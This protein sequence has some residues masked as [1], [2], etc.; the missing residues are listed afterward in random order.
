MPRRHHTFAVDT[1]WLKTPATGVGTYIRSTIEALARLDTVNR[2]KLWGAAVSTGNP[3]F[4]YHRF[5]GRWQWWWEKWWNHFNHP[6]LDMVGPRADLWHFTNYGALPT[7]KPYVVSVCDLAWLYYPEQVLPT[8]L[9][10]LKAYVPKSL[11]RAAHV[12]TISEATKKDIVKEFG[13]P[14]SR[15]SV[16]HLAAGPQFAKPASGQ[17]V[18][19]LKQKYGIEGDYLL[20]VGTLEPRKNLR[21]LLEA[22]VTP[23]GR[24]LNLPLVVVGGQGWR[25][26]E[27]RELIAKLGL[28]NR[29]ILTGYVPDEELPALYCGA[30]LFVFPS[31][32]EG[33]GIPVVEAMTAGAAVITTK[34]SAIPEV[35]GKAARYV[36]PA[37]AGELA[38]VI[39][40]LL[41]DSKQRLALI[42]AGRKQAAKFS[43][44]QTAKGTLDVYQKVLKE[45]GR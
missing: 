2:Y 16:T 43:W 34:V 42:K 37:N 38:E 44:E 25:A 7:S 32:Y 4:S 39:T 40:E 15:I 14:A 17:K 33:F 10:Y 12:L 27:A 3:H 11:Q 31:V 30:K 36:D 19:Y 8:H 41:G 5:G 35:A 20:A 9:D 22:L 1:R 21:T 45:R 28:S 23:A 18:A 13:V 26:E 24:K 6:S 29:V